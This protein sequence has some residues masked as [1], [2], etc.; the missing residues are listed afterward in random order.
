MKNS[1]NYDRWMGVDGVMLKPKGQGVGCLTMFITWTFIVIVF[2]AKGDDL[3]AIPLLLLFTIVGICIE[4]MVSRSAEIEQVSD[5][6]AEIDRHE[7]M[8]D[9]KFIVKFSNVQYVGGH[10]VY[11]IN[12]QG[13]LGLTEDELVFY[14]NKTIS[15]GRWAVDVK[16]IKFSIPLHCIDKVLYDTSEKITLGRFLVIGLASFAFKKK[17]YY[18][19]VNYKSDSQ[20]ENQVVFETGN[21]MN[22]YFYNELNVAR[23]KAINKHKEEHTIEND[24]DSITDKIRELAKL[25]DDGILTDEEFNEK[26][27][28]LLNKL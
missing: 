7:S 25:R 2:L 19:I 16:D 26:K 24:S 20:V 22:Q 1:Y 18:L 8:E 6:I 11:S 10:E 23:N 21:K 4:V 28:D 5:K 15:D 27:K 12:E 13:I 3:P 9:Q 14:K 17:T